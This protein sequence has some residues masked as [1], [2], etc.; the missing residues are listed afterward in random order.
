MVF[1]LIE[2]PIVPFHLLQ[3]SFH[4]CRRYKGLIQTLNS[5]AMDQENDE[6]CQK[7]DLTKN[8]SKNQQVEPVKAKRTSQHIN[9]REGLEKSEIKIVLEGYDIKSE[10]LDVQVINDKILIIKVESEDLKFDKKFNVPS[11]SKVESIECKIDSKEEGKHN[12]V[13]TIPKENIIKQIPI[14]YMEQ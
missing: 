1:Y 13:I 14:D 3:P 2:E 7:S 12:I 8:E 4:Q 11:R 9:I 5:E 10:H 6:K